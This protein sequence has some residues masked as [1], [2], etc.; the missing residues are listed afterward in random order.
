VITA[1]WNHAVVTPPTVRGQKSQWPELRPEELAD[2][3]A[4]LQSL[5]VAR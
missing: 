5:R 4:F 2:L 1:L 3:V